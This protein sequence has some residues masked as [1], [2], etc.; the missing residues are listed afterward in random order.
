FTAPLVIRIPYG[1]GI[2]AAEHHSESFET[3]YSHTPGLKVVVPSRPVDA[4]GLLAAAIADPD[5]VIFLEPIRAYRS[6]KEDVPDAPYT[7]PIGVASI[8]RAGDDVTLIAYGAMMRETRQAADVLA[9]AG[10]SAEVIDLRTLVPLDVE[11][12][13]ASV[14]NTG[15]AVVIHEAART[16]GFGA[17]IVATLQERALYSLRAPIERVTGW[18]VIVPLRR[19]EQHYTPGVDRIVAA[20][21]RTYREGH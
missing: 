7:T 12:I 15:R 19:A 4:K 18:D 3:I 17:E 11:S 8:E 9:D 6:L 5:P 20:A 14:Q 10:I 21:M 13:V 2:G 1:G 16:T